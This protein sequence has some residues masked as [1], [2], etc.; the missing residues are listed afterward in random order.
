MPARLLLVAGICLAAFASNPVHAEE[1][2]PLFNGENLDGWTPKIRGHEAGENFADTFRVE[3]GLLKV[4]FDN[5]EGRYRGRYG[6]LFYKDSFSNY[7]IRV[8]CRSVGEQPEGSPGWARRNNGIML[9]CQSPES[10]VLDQ[11]F[12]A[13]LEVQILAGLDDGQ[14]R[15]TA[16]LCTP[17][18]NVFI[19]GKLF[20]P[21]CTSSS[22]KTVPHGEWMTIEAEV[23]GDS[24][25]HFLN[26]E[27]VLAYTRPQLD[28]NDADAKRLLDAGAEQE[29]TSGY[30]SI[31][32]E[33]A[34][35][36][37][38]KI[39]ILELDP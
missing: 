37:F 9:H 2:R 32:S 13:S 28:P 39:E 19:D 29:L 30:I 25:K 5:Y 3:D 21:H 35:Y 15:S 26:G 11:Q 12:P 31:Q 24:V 14:P 8:E 10:M 22:S 34:P 27:Q 7:R 16:N 23:R 17:G 20:T 38:R 18:T 33:S 36:D 6:H 1:W 4:R